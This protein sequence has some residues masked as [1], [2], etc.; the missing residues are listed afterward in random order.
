VTGISSDIRNSHPCGNFGIQPDVIR[1][2]RNHLLCC[3]FAMMFVMVRTADAHA[4][5][6]FDGKEPPAS[7]HIA[8]GDVHPCEKGQSQEHKGDKDVKLSPDL[9][10]KKP[11][12]TEVWIPYVAVFVFQISAVPCCEPITA[13]E[14]TGDLRPPLFRLPPL[15]GPPV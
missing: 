12:P 8:D 13:I 10:V 5:F 4:H 11:L 14:Q 3:L 1:A 6:C 15:R 7:I 2:S 9:L